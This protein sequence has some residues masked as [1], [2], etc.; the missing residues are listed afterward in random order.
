M[1]R[2]NDIGIKFIFLFIV[3]YIQLYN[4]GVFTTFVNL[5][6]TGT[7]ILNIQN[8]YIYRIVLILKVNGG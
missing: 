3:G 5:N 6:S 7:H 1:K 2:P 4:F 8:T